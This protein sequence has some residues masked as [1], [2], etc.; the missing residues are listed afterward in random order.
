MSASS[1]FLIKCRFTSTCPLTWDHYMVGHTW[2]KGHIE[3]NHFGLSVAT[4]NPSAAGWS[5]DHINHANKAKAKQR[6]QKPC[7]HGKG[8]VKDT[9]TL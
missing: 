9:E 1:F 6:T 2:S 5:V 4:P 7:E 3:V 8:K